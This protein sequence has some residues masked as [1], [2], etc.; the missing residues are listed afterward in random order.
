[1][2]LSDRDR[3]VLDI[4]LFIISQSIRDEAIG[5]RTRDTLRH[6]FCGNTN[7]HQA[8]CGAFLAP[9]RPFYVSSG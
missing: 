8:G 7:H 1:M 5:E 9:Q 2:A 3:I 6:Q 4:I